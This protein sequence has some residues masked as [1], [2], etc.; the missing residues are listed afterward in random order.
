M[1]AKERIEYWALLAEVIGAI[2]VI[3]SVIY[4]AVQVSASTTEM[5]AQTAYNA[6]R[7]AQQSVEMQVANPDLGELVT[8][9]ARSAEGLTPTEWDRLAGYYFLMYN[10]WEYTYLL[11]KSDTMSLDFWEAH[12]GYMR[13]EIIRKPTMHKFWTESQ[14]SYS[15]K[16]RK[17]VDEIFEQQK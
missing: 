7:L 17:Y 6:L 9:G 2:G 4:L 12:D 16:F 11:S 1:I 5:Q 8:R 14:S 3:V 10:A 13:S 15:T